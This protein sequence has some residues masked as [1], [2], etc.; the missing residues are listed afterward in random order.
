[1]KFLPVLIEYLIRCGVSRGSGLRSTLLSGIV[2][3][4][5][6]SHPSGARNS[7]SINRLNSR[8]VHGRNIECEATK[9]Q[10]RC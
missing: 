9:C 4:N 7:P 8:V 10:H 3:K 6:H 2:P 1:M 5:L